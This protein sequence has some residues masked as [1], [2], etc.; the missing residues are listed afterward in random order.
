MVPVLVGCVVSLQWL[1]FIFSTVSK[2]PQC[3]VGGGDSSN[4]DWEWGDYHFLSRCQG[5]LSIQRWC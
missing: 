2:A 3:L 4:G 5:V 1:G